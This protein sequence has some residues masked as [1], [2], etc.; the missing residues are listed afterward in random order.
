MT[1]ANRA[2]NGSGYWTNY[3]YLIW[4][5]ADDNLVLHPGVCF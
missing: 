5:L 3:N 2:T 1:K 4:L